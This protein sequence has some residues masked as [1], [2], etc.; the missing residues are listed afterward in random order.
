MKP[1]YNSGKLDDGRDYMNTEEL[2]E[3][4]EE[5]VCI[6]RFVY[7]FGVVGYLK[8]FKITEKGISC[9]DSNGTYCYYKITNKRMKWH[10]DQMYYDI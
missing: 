9:Y 8:Q 10:L 4:F 6:S 7:S 3:M 5:W 1:I 2:K